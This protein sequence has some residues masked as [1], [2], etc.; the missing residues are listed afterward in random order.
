MSSKTDK[1]LNLYEKACDLEPVTLESILYH[2]QHGSFP[3]MT[4]YDD[5]YCAW[6]LT[7]SERHFIDED[8]ERI[9]SLILSFLEANGFPKG[10]KL[11]MDQEGYVC[12]LIW[13]KDEVYYD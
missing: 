5:L 9:F 7:H 3:V 4:R 11:S 2:L 10:G 12:V 1:P 8:E 6:A 13:E